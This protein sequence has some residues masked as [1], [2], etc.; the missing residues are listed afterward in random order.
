V[1]SSFLVRGS[2]LSLLVINRFKNFEIRWLMILL[3]LQ[4]ER[5]DM[6]SG[7]DG[8]DLPLLLFLDDFKSLAA[9][10]AIV[11]KAV[12]IILQILVICQ[13][14]FREFYLKRDDRYHLD[15]GPVEHRVFRALS[16]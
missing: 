11:K 13:I 15:W 4:S 10:W 12:W 14:H 6:L 2:Y 16:N 3:G 5:V 9:F 7:L 1:R 8:L